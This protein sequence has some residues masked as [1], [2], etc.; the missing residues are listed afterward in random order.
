MS[1]YQLGA[2]QP[3]PKDHGGLVINN[4][5][6]MHPSE[7]MFPEALDTSVDHCPGEA[8]TARRRCNHDVLEESAAAIVASQRAADQLAIIDGNDA[9]ARVSGKQP[10]NAV[11]A[12]G[13]RPNVDPGVLFHNATTAS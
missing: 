10:F 13:H 3:F 5:I 11:S 9:Q 8:L 12:V 6:Q 1:A 4:D 2:S 7:V